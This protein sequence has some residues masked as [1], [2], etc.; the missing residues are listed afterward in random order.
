MKKKLLFKVLVIALALTSGCG[1]NKTAVEEDKK[2]VEAEFEESKEDKK[3]VEAEF[4]E[5]KEDEKLQKTEIELN[6]EDEKPILTEFE[7][8]GEIKDIGNYSCYEEK[9]VE[10]FKENFSSEYELYDASELTEEMLIN[11]NGKFIIERCIGVVTDKNDGSGRLLNYFDPY[12]YFISYN[13]IS[14]EINNGT[15]VLS[16]MVYDPSSNYIDDIMERYDFVVCRN[17]ED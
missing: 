1:F 4:D 15:I 6:M 17:Y 3:S 10:Y 13:C 8:N 11:R 7:I 2:S 12:H 16:Y 14:E 9:F 5:S